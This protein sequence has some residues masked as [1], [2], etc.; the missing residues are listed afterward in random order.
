MPKSEYTKVMHWKFDEDGKRRPRSTDPFSAGMVPGF[1]D[2][3]YPDWLQREMDVLLPE[4]ISEKYGTMEQTMLNGD[5][6][7]IEKKRE[8]AICRDLEKLGYKLVKREDLTFY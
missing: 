4:E 2:G 8:K 3:D 1:Y 6:L 7:H 5:Y